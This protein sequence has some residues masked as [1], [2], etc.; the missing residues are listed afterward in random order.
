MGILFAPLVGCFSAPKQ[1]SHS[2]LRW[3]RVRVAF[4]W[5]KETPLLA[6]MLLLEQQED[7]ARRAAPRAAPALIGHRQERALLSF[8]INQVIPVLSITPS[9]Y[10]LFLSLNNPMPSPQPPFTPSDSPRLTPDW[11]T[12]CVS[13]VTYLM[14]GC[15][16]SMH[17]L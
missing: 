2:L 16:I 8:L 3:K 10:T 5:T 14:C 7:L 15:L 12:A 9:F 4:V 17:L 11:R 13:H 1:P 6:F